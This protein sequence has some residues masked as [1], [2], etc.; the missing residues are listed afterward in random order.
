M[1]EPIGTETVEDQKRW[2]AESMQKVKQ[3]HYRM[4][5]E[6][7]RK[8]L[9]GVLKEAANML[10]ELKTSLLSPIHYYELF[11]LVFDH[12]QEVYIFL[13]G[14]PG[15]GRVKRQIYELVQRAASLIPRLYLLIVA[16]VVLIETDSVPK[17]EV[18]TDIID[19]MKG[20]QN[21]IRGLFLRE[22]FNRMVKRVLP[23]A[24]AKPVT[25]EPKEAEEESQE[26]EGTIEDSIRIV[27]RNFI[28]MNKLW[29][30]L[31]YAQAFTLIDK[32]KCENERNQLRQLVGTNIIRLSQFENINPEIYAFSVLPVLLN[33]IEKCG[34]RIAQQYLLDS[35]I[36]AFP[37]QF[38]FLT[39]DTLF[40]VLSKLK[41]GVVI[42]DILVGLLQRFV[43]FLNNEDTYPEGVRLC[44]LLITNSGLVGRVKKQ[45]EERKLM[46]SQQGKEFAEDESTL[47]S[48]YNPEH[49]C[50]VFHVISFYVSDVLSSFNSKPQPLSITS[51]LKIFIALLAFA[52]NVTHFNDD[53][54]IDDIFTDI[55]GVFHC[56]HI[57]S[58]CEKEE[59]TLLRTLLTTPL[60]VPS[61]IFTVLAMRSFTELAGFLS[62]RA[63]K[64]LALEIA[65]TLIDCGSENIDTIEKVDNLLTFLSPVLIGKT[66]TVEEIDERDVQ[67]IASGV[68][69]VVVEESDEQLDTE[70]SLV[71]RCVHLVHT[72]DPNI[73]YGILNAMK[74]HYER[75]G[76]QRTPYT[77]P[78]LLFAILR[79][80]ACQEKGGDDHSAWTTQMLELADQVIIL[81]GY[82]APRRSLR[83]FL[84]C[85]RV[86]DSCPDQ[87]KMTYH[88]L[89]N[90]FI[91]FEDHIVESKSQLESLY[92]MIGTIFSL[93][94]MP[95]EDYLTA[96]KRVCMLS[97]SLMRKSDQCKA[98]CR[99]F[100]L[101]Y[102]AGS[103]I[104]KGFPDEKE[105]FQGKVENKGGQCKDVEKLLKWIKK[106][107]EVAMY[108]RSKRLCA[109]QILCVVNQCISVCKRI[110]RVEGRSDNYSAVVTEVTRLMEEASRASAVA[111]H[112]RP[113]LKGIVDADPTVEELSYFIRSCEE[114]KNKL[115]AEKTEEKVEEKVE[116]EVEEKVEEP[117]EK[118]EEDLKEEE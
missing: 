24:P 18:L 86:A 52:S 102:N 74:R 20:V 2:V 28:E 70:L 118:V 11:N 60:K 56:N 82:V 55:V 99:S 72:E 110:E 40:G 13:R 113:Q 95:L 16:G 104:T 103:L 19:M 33:Q 7:S 62:G 92:C 51:T 14:I 38:H 46:A 73:L 77:L 44:S 30:R 47:L 6:I 12:M 59:L 53:T 71:A 93:T 42:S 66:V 101:F 87:T 29:V 111:S 117:V 109:Y 68:D 25:E 105:E 49:P 8:N 50:F 115:T 67:S 26:I 89:T 39:V 5:E 97:L 112:D 116:E 76:P 108:E 58:V 100:H 35:I 78:P 21:P 36:H 37:D 107:A 15:D 3:A 9:P 84:E 4:R 94:H 69:A 63:R 88:F 43:T 27:L 81:Y 96:S 83:L 90:A 48:K 57:E 10:S 31:Q 80:T 85:A 17:V 41:P 34:D 65:K 106:T 23:D 79:H 98:L 32:K 75:G 1:D 54:L 22:F 64:D 91:S 114:E 61:H 45:F